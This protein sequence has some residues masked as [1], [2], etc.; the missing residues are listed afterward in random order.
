MAI[1]KIDK[2]WNNISDQKVIYNDGQVWIVSD[3]IDKSKDLPIINVPMNH[4]CLDFNIAEIK[5]R[6]FVSHMKLIL[7]ANMDFPII[8]DDEAQLFDGRHRVAKALLNGLGDIKAVRFDKDPPPT[9]TKT[10]E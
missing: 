1:V 9:Y 2:P 4:L 3:L 5:V 10:K 6:K 7:D 8:L